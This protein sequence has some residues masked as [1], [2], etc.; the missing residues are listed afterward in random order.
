MAVVVV[1]CFVVSK[2]RSTSGSPRTRLFE[3]KNGRERKG[4]PRAKGVDAVDDEIYGQDMVLQA[5]KGGKKGGKR[6]KWR[7]P[8]AEEVVGKKVNAEDA[9]DVRKIKSTESMF[10]T[11]E[12]LLGQREEFKRR[13]DSICAVHGW[14]WM[15][16]DHTLLGGFEPA[17]ILRSIKAEISSLEPAS[18]ILD[19]TGLLLEL[20]SKKEE[21]EFLSEVPFRA[22]VIVRC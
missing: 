1:F 20:Q 17:S 15:S 21:L 10:E 22:N 8:E 12:E 7:P 5:P 2:L 19:R 4:K 13:L 18:A 11:W 6:D 16:A 9:E 3:M 14:S